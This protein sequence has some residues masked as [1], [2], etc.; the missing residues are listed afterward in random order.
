MRT[1]RRYEEKQQCSVHES[2]H[3][4][5]AESQIWV[6]CQ[7]SIQLFAL[8]LDVHSMVT[9]F[10][11]YVR[12][13]QSCTSPEELHLYLCLYLYLYLYRSLYHPTLVHTPIYWRQ[14]FRVNMGG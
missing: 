5:F 12:V 2:T 9:L 1:R 14:E 7:H 8:H 13:V 6:N 11:L 10:S 3:S 4:R